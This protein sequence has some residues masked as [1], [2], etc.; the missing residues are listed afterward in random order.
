MIKRKITLSVA[1]QNG[2]A[3]IVSLIIL[4]AITILGVANMESSSLEMK[5]VASQ[6]ERNINFSLAESTLAAAE[7]QVVQSGITKS[8]LQSCGSDENSCVF[9]E[10]AGNDFC[11]QGNYTNAMQEIECETVNTEDAGWENFRRPWE[12]DEVWGS[13]K[14]AA[15]ANADIILNSPEA[16]SNKRSIKYFV[17]FM[18][19]SPGDGLV[20]NGA[21]GNQDNGEP[22]YR[23][24][25][26][27]QPENN[28]KQA[29]VLQSTIV[30]PI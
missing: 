24:T 10:C 8:T 25:V 5:M 23:I 16:N 17:E 14:T 29:V 21:E 13:A 9:P 22:L 12:L 1:K 26:K 4:A 19:F 3:L 6:K 20:F 18:C 27:V 30:V 7:R 2:A 15:I 11:F 28:K